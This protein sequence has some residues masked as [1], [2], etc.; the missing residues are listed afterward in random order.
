MSRG[1]FG[2]PFV[3]WVMFAVVAAASGCA[4]PAKDISFDPAT[5]T[6]VVAIPD[7]TDVWP[8]YNRSQAL[9]LIQSRVGPDF[10]IIE[11]QTVVIGQTTSNDRQVNTQT[12]SERKRILPTEIEMKF[13]RDMTTT[14]DLTEYRIAYRRKPMAAAPA[15]ASG[16]VVQTHYQSG[17]TGTP[18]AGGI[19]PSVAPGPVLRP[20]GDAPSAG[21]TDGKCTSK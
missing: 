21:C 13:I 4:S 12:P 17:T 16:S 10:E 7:N 18:P 6:G 20:A 9:A 19:V 15:P 5:G 11:E 1:S 3:T 8:T 2:G 14:R